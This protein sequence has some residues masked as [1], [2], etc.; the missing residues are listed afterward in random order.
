MELGPPGAPPLREA[1]A[2]LY[3][4]GVREDPGL[5]V[6]PL[7]EPLD[8][9][10]RSPRLHGPG[11]TA[12]AVV[13]LDERL[14][15]ARPHEHLG[16]E[17]LGHLHRF[18]RIDRIGD[19]DRTVGI[20]RITERAEVVVA[21]IGRIGVVRPTDD[22]ARQTLVLGQVRP[23][24]Q[25]LAGRRV[26]LV[27]RLELQR[28]EPPFGRQQ[29]SAVLLLPQR[30][31]RKTRID[32]RRRPALERLEIEVQPAV[33]RQRIELLPSQQLLDRLALADRADEILLVP[34]RE[35]HQLSRGVV[36]PSP[37]HRGVPLPAVGPHDRRVGLKR[38]LVKV[39][40]D[41]AVH[42]VARQRTLAPYRQQPAAASDDLDLLG[43]ADVAR[44]FRAALDRRRRKK[45]GI[46]A[47]FE[48][49]LHPAVELR[50]QGARVGGDRHAAV[51]V[52][53]QHIG[54]QERRGPEA[55]AVLRGHGDDQPADASCSEG[56]QHPV[57]SAVEGLQL[58]EGIDTEGKIGKCRGTGRRST[59]KKV[60]DTAY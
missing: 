50:G 34:A 20:D 41:E 29:R 11:K 32:R 47:R 18:T 38:I 9:Y 21:R 28:I 39:V 8:P 14:A 58:Q 22:L 16:H 53:S 4:S 48:D 24:E 30:L 60:A 59:R 33:G 56:L 7:M 10:A 31:S 15:R 37:H 36:H 42:A 26:P 2:V 35:D 23:V 12:A 54:R 45:G 46:L 3:R 51:G 5:L 25:P 13:A 52:E 19:V 57:V 43:G 1:E 6:G 27:H 49:P 17:R 55:L 44:R 40:E